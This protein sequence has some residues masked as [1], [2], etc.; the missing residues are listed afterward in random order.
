MP[1]LLLDTHV[2]VWFPTGDPRLSARARAAIEDGASDL[3]VSA[4]TAFELTD[5]Q[6]RGRVALQETIEEIAG[7]MALSIIDLPADTW[8]I[9]AGLADIH[10]DPI[11]RMLVGHAIA[12]GFTVV[13]SDSAIRRYP[14]ETLW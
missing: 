12:G 4:V 11:D 14:V 3:F 7:E 1:R 6:R 10:G 2:L 5:L 9:A 13:T 8:R